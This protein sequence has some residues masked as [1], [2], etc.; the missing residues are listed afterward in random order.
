MGKVHKTIGLVIKV[1][2]FRKYCL[3][4][5]KLCENG[6]QAKVILSN[7]I[8]NLNIGIRFIILPSGY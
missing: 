3:V 7:I 4:F 6:I 2:V 8:N 1:G 5:V